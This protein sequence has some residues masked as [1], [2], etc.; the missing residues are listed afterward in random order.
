ML[1]LNIF[2]KSKKMRG[3]ESNG[4]IPDSPVADETK[5]SY[6]SQKITKINEEIEDNVRKILSGEFNE[7]REDQ[8]NNV[9]EDMGSGGMMNSHSGGFSHQNHMRPLQTKLQFLKSVALFFFHISGL[10]LIRHMSY[11]IL[12]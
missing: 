1:S 11:R 8:D 12:K 7:K 2:G 5:I 4:T 3:C 9:M 6:Y 10:L